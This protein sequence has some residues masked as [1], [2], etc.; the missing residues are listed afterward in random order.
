MFWIARVLDFTIHH[1]S[2]YRRPEQVTWRN[3]HPYL[4][5]HIRGLRWRRERAGLFTELPPTLMLVPR[6]QVQAFEYGQDRENWVV[7]VLTE[8]IREVADPTMVELVS[9]GEVVRLPRHTPVRQHHLP[10]FQHRFLAMQE[11]FRDPS[12]ASQLRVRC[13]VAHVLG[14]II[15]EAQGI[16]AASPA[17]RLKALIDRDETC[18]RSL[19]ALSRECGFSSDH[20]RRLFA[21]EFGLNPQAYRQRRRLAM[22][23]QLLTETSQSVKEIAA[24]LG[25]RHDSHFCQVYRDQ[26]GLTPS[27]AR[28]L[29]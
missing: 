3:P 28:Q 25:F 14:F 13:E 5:L 29:R 6:G 8:D 11:A 15:E 1:A 19:D 21:S 20:L 12:P 2:V 18:E 24:K 9:A 7:Q 27:E 16:A 22:A 26:Y 17:G 4:S 10:R 23:T